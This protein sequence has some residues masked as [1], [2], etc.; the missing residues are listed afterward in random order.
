MKPTNRFVPLSVLSLIFS[1]SLLVTRGSQ[2][3]MFVDNNLYFLLCGQMEF[4][5]A[6]G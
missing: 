1:L 5:H 2:A 6:I 4:F 3:D